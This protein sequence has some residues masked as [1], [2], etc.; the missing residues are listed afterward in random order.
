MSTAL[1]ADK[2]KATTGSVQSKNRLGILLKRPPVPGPTGPVIFEARWKG[3]VGNLLI[4]TSATPPSVS[5]AY[6]PT[7]TGR[8]KALIHSGGDNGDDSTDEKQTQDASVEGNSVE[9]T[10][11]WTIPIPSI[12]E[13]KKIGGLGWKGRLVVGWAVG[14]EVRDGLE[15]VDTKGERVVVT[16]V[17]LR[18]ELFN[19][20]ASIGGQKW[21]SW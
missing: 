1:G 17:P 6:A 7:V 19:R 5:F 10:P 20:L 16:A 15:I 3:K 12:A 2:V 8:V 14:T 11:V 13:L 9:V 18:E 21:E 4:S